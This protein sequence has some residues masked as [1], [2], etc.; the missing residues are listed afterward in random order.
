MTWLILP[1][2]QNCW[3][4]FLVKTK[5]D[6]VYLV[7]NWRLLSW[8]VRLQ[9]TYVFHWSK[10]E[11]PMNTLSVF[12]CPLK[13]LIGFLQ[14]I[15]EHV[16]LRL[17]CR[18]FKSQV[19]TAKPR[20]AQLLHK[21]VRI[22]LWPTHQILI[23]FD[24]IDSQALEGAYFCDFEFPWVSG[25]LFLLIL[26]QEVRILLKQGYDVFLDLITWTRY[27]ITDITK[28]CNLSSACTCKT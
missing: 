10:K 12:V 16:S 3:N 26:T 13:T 17:F 6:S 14:R 24:C 7:D 22:I 20:P 1:P 2:L 23:A 5:A 25:P 4:S 21:A 9:I 15:L 28:L 19:L 18:Y 8:H 11:N 27:E